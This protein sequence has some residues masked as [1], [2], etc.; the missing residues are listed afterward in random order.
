MLKFCVYGDVADVFVATFKIILILE[1]K[2][3]G[4]SVHGNESVGVFVLA[5]T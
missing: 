3:I 2:Y 5:R 1:R 4:D